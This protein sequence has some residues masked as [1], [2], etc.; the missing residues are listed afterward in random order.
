MKM[1]VPDYGKIWYYDKAISN[2]L[3]LKNLVNKFRV[4]YNSHQDDAFNIQTNIGII[5]FRRD[6]KG[7]YVFKNTY[8]TENSN[9]F[10][11]VE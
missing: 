9:V 10:T 11:T 4:T 1:M 7:L 5:K 8:T 6:K 2:I 3:S